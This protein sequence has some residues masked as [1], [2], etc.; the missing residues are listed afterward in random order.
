MRGDCVTC[1]VIITLA[2]NRI[3]RHFHLYNLQLELVNPLP[4]CPFFFL[5]TACGI[6]DIYIDRPNVSACMAGP[7]VGVS[8]TVV[9]D[10]QTGVAQQ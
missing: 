7:A 10:E 9:L 1:L 4:I 2:R 5:R 6:G 3:V 8:G